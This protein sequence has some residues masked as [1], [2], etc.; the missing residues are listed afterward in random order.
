MDDTIIIII[1]W[2]GFMRVSYSD[3][4]YDIHITL[5]NLV[6]HANIHATENDIVACRLLVPRLSEK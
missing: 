6:I 5:V 3:F 2:K 1:Q 4:V